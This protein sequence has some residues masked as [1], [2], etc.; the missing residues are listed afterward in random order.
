MIRVLHASDPEEACR[1][2]DFHGVIQADQTRLIRDLRPYLLCI[3]DGEMA[4]AL[5]PLLARWKIP[6]AWG[7]RLLFFSVSSVDQLDQWTGEDGGS[8]S[9][10]DPVREAIRRTLERDFVVPCRERELRLGGSPGI[11]GILNVTPDSFSDAGKYDSAEAAVRRG[12]EMVAEGADIIDV[13]GESTRPGSVP[14][15][16]DEE[17]AR[18]VPVIRE[19]AR[20]TGA[21]LSVDTTKAAVAREAISAG[22]HIVNDTSA[23]ADDPE[24]AGLIGESGCAVVLM[25]R[26]GTPATMQLAPF[27][28]S[29]FDEMLE[30]IQKRID[31][32]VK[33][34]IPKER[35]LIDPGVGFGKRF[36]DNL[37]L[38]RHLPDLRNLGRPVVFGPSRKAFIGRITGREASGR[39]FGTAASVAFAASRGV[40]ILRVHDVKEMKEVV[41][42]VTAIREGDEC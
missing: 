26:R 8:R 39:I 20:E 40:D 13:G 3:S 1:R 18:V 16:A 10:L 14:V 17:I 2:L 5:F 36:E 31:V 9:A 21:L 30:E 11:I 41:R 25:H 6:L 15:P 23:L 37:A 29:L 24:M 22:V 4:H 27:Y 19:L 38:H 35:I 32:A 42:V 12:L 28:E 33:A 34:G 7:K